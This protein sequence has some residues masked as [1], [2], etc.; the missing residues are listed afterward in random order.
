MGARVIAVDRLEDRLYMARRQGAET[1]NFENEDPVETVLALT[2][3]IGVGRVIDAVGMEAQ[4]G[5]HGPTGHASHEQ[6]GESADEQKKIEPQAIKNGGQW[7]AGDAPTQALDW[8]AESLCKAGQLAI[9]G[10][11]PPTECFPSARR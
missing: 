7:M 9:I 11:Y 1:V 2:G 8:A 5:H 10:V 3:G 6:A 4:H